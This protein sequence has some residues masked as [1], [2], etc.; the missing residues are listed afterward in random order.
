M[1]DTKI[2]PRPIVALSP[3]SRNA[4]TH[5]KKQIRQMA[6]SIRKFGFTNLK[7]P[8]SNPC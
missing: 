5:S 1:P 3:W 4:R 6:D 7:F 8:A 2:T